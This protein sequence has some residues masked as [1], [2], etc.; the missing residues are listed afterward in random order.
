MPDAK[1]AITG[2]ARRR[3]PMQRLRRKIASPASSAL[4]Y[5]VFCLVALLFAVCIEKMPSAV[6][7]RAAQLREML[8]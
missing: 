8:G 6:L 2:P 4:A 3:T 1:T 5:T 7:E